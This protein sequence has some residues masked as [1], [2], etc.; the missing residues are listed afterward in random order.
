[1]LLNDQNFLFH[2]EKLIALRKVAQ[3]LEAASK[4]LTAETPSLIQP[5]NFKDSASSINSLS[6]F[7]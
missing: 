7:E 5:N 2:C 4:P 3:N 1:M 6:N